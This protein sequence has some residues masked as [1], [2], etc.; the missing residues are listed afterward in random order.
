[1]KCEENKEQEEMSCYVDG[2]QKESSENLP[3]NI[4][5]KT[6]TFLYISHIFIFYVPF[7]SFVQHSHSHS[8]PFSQIYPDIFPNP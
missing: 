6:T 2:N 5:N 7:A 1:M 3:L 8:I 4:P